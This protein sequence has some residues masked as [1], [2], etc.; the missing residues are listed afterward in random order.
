ML[1][2]TANHG[3]RL[4]SIVALL[5]WGRSFKKNTTYHRTT[6]RLSGSKMAHKQLSLGQFGFTAAINRVQTTAIKRE[7]KQTELNK[8]DYE[9]TERVRSFIPS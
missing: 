4:D 9:S 6:Q 7:C 1:Y 2:L 8:N 3:A 5:S